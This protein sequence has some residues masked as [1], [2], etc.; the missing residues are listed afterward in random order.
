MR[1]QMAPI[2]SMRPRTVGVRRPPS[3]AAARWAM[4]VARSPLRSSSGTT[5]STEIR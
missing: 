3:P 4:W 5:R 1:T 2:C